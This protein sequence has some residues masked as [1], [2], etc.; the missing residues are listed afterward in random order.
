M[1]SLI[2]NC[3]LLSVL[4]VV[5]CNK[6]EVTVPDKGSVTCTHKHGNYS[7]DSLCHYSCEEGYQPTMQQPL[8]CTEDKTWSESPPT[9]E[10]ELQHFFFVCMFNIDPEG[11]IDEWTAASSDCVRSNFILEQRKTC[12]H[13]M[14]MILFPPPVVQCQ[15]LSRP[16]R[17]S[18][19]CSNP[20]GSSSYKSTCVF[21]C[22]E[23]YLLVGSPS[24]TLQCESSGEWNNSQPFCVGMCT[25]RMSPC[26]TSCSVANIL[27][28]ESD[29]NEEKKDFSKAIADP[30]SSSV[31]QLSSARLSRTYRT[32]KSAVEA[33]QI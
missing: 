25:F 6:D 32:S 12:C 31:L 8:R 5:K 28:I 26:R 30:C 29:F 10:C 21:T 2:Y 9:C 18:M 24:D 17:G 16:D 13:V 1:S 23:G 33:M 15:E 7:Y 11:D 4:V 20:L 22:D 3:V 27:C 14:L 19:K